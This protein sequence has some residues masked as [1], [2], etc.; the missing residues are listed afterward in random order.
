MVVVI[1]I[2][3]VTRTKNTKKKQKDRKRKV[4]LGIPAILRQNLITRF[5]CFWIF[6]CNLQYK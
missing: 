4:T 5:K 3:L 2:S 6:F 1:A